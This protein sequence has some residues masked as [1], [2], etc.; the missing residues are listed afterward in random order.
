MK[1]AMIYPVFVLLVNVLLAGAMLGYVFPAFIPLFQG[2]Q[3]PLLTRFFLG[4]SWLA[5]SKLFWVVALLGGIELFL[6]FSQPE[7]QEKL[8]RFC[9]AIP[10]L[11]PLLRSAARTRFCAVLAVTT[12]TGLPL[13]RAMSLAAK[14]SGD[15]EF[16]DL[17]ANLQREV[18]EGAPID[19]HFL[20]HTEI[21]GLV[22]SHGMSLCQAT[23]NTDQ[24]C[25]HLTTL[26]Q[27]DTE[28]R[29]QQLQ[30]VLEPLLIGMVSLTTGTLL[31]SIYWPLGKFLQ[32]LLG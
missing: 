8:H 31:L 9:L 13:M 11:S 32:T 19:E 10:V 12:R 23:G 3:L 16:A 29:V 26:F 21:Y 25:Q 5:S 6:F 30:G 24:V 15:P 18:R 17:D 20:G 27:S 14:A 22:L 28:V 1:S 4:L 7:H 2:E